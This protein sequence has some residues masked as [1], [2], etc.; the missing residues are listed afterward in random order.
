MAYYCKVFDLT[1]PN[2][3]V[4]MVHFNMHDDANNSIVQG[5]MTNGFNVTI[6]DANG[7]VVS[8][9]GI[10]KRQRMATEFNFYAERLITDAT[11]VDV[12]FDALKADAIGFRYPGV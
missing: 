10:Q 3:G 8:E 4:I 9:T 11:L 5:P 7:V 2:L 6:R 1:R 12:N